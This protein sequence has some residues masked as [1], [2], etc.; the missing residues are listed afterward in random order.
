MNEGHNMHSIFLRRKILH[1]SFNVKENLWLY[2][3]NYVLLKE[4]T[5]SILIKRLIDYIIVLYGAVM[6]YMCI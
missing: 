3:H 6:V 2:I 1:G 5:S 4:N